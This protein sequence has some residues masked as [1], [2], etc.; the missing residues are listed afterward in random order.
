MPP[1]ATGAAVS[2][3]S[4]SGGARFR[5]R[6]GLGRCAGMCAD[7]HRSKWRSDSS[8]RTGK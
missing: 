3:N 7:V 4:L 1:I 6:L 5:G 8:C 2:F